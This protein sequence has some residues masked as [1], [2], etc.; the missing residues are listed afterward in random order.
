[1]SY[2]ATASRVRHA[3]T[4][5]IGEW[6]CARPGVPLRRRPFGG[7]VGQ[8]CGVRLV[9]VRAFPAGALEEDRTEL[10]LTRVERADP[11]VPWRLLGLQRV[12]HVVDLDEVLRRRLRD[13]LRGSAGTPRNGAR[14]SRAGR[15]RSGRPPGAG[16][17]PWRHRPSGSPT[18]PRRSRTRR[19][20]RTRP[21]SGPPSGVKEKIPLK[22]SSTLAAAQRRQQLT[23]LL[24]DLDE[25][26]LGEGQH[27]RHGGGGDIAVVVEI[28]AG[29]PASV[30]GRSCRSR[31]GPACS[32]KYR[33]PSW[34]RRIGS[35]DLARLVVAPDQLGDL[36]RLHVLVRERQQRHVHADHRADRR[37]PEAGARHD[38]VG[39]D[40]PL[41]RC[42]RR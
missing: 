10:L 21:I 28:V 16:R 39:L 30:G 6:N 17:R 9:P 20:P 38:D 1:M 8:Q 12:Q 26:V 14:R 40:H 35:P 32:R 11:Q 19:R 23:A 7:Q 37:A 33:S 15:T 27:R 13:V 24:P 29:A 36:T 41:R 42:A 2:I 25:V 3:S 31:C 22:P 18:R 5:A 4:A 34:W